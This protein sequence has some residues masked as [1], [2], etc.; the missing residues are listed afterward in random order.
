MGS[1]IPIPSRH[2]LTISEINEIENAITA[3]NITLKS[4]ALSKI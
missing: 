3:Y 2:V 1:L 4:I